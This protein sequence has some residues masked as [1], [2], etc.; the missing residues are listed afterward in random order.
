MT[1]HIP[2]ALYVFGRFTVGVSETPVVTAAGCRAL[3][4]IDRPIRRIPG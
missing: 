4:S 2:M 1:F 3:S